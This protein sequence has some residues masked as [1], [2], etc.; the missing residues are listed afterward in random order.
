MWQACWYVLD[1]RLRNP[2]L[3]Q[4]HLCENCKRLQRAGAESRSSVRGGK[5]FWGVWLEVRAWTDWLV[6][7]E[8]S[9]Q[10]VRVDPWLPVCFKGDYE[11][12]WL[13]CQQVWGAAPDADP[14]PVEFKSAL[15]TF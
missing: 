2:E 3:F 8:C 15:A 7:A 4:G 13:H 14:Q 9:S 5:V 12:M 1:Y 11:D 10:S 6:K